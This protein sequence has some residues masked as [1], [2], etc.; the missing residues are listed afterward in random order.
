MAPKGKKP[1]SRPKGAASPRSKGAAPPRPRIAYL[2]KRSALQAI[3]GARS[4]DDRT[5]G[6]IARLLKRGDLTVARMRATHD[7]HMATITEV[8]RVFDELGAEVT[9][10]SEFRG[11]LTTRDFDLCVTVGG[12]GTLLRASH[13][14]GDVPMLG[15]NSAPLTSVG[16]FC[17]ADRTDARRAIVAALERKLDGSTLT[18]MRVSIGAKVVAERVLNDALYCHTSPAATSRYILELGG[19]IEE[20]KSSGL[21]IG[22]AAGSTAAQRSAG[23]KVLR[24]ESRDLQLV[25]REPYTPQGGRYRL[26]CTLIREGESLTVRS[27]MRSSVIF[28]DG[29]AETLTPEFGDIITFTHAKEPLCLLGVTPNRKKARIS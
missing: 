4:A 15:I 25:V 27:K 14:V 26:R 1:A 18:R 7:A 16:F 2:E 6:R 12:D 11:D 21:W 5:A 29:P 13:F 22:P 28:L 3:A 9:D 10:L 17:G 23:G 24:L 20:Q 8:G 19:V